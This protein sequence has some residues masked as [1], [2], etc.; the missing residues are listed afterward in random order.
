L[1]PV[2]AKRSLKELLLAI[3]P[4]GEDADFEWNPDRSS[5][6]L[7]GRHQRH[8]GAPQEPAL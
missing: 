3:P 1:I 8:L 2:K 4:V 7:P 6:E 5:F